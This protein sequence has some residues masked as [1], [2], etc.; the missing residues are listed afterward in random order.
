MS[1]AIEAGTITAITGT[2][3]RPHSLNRRIK[4]R[5]INEGIIRLGAQIFNN[6]SSKLEVVEQGFSPHE[7][8]KFE[9]ILDGKMLRGVISMGHQAINEIPLQHL[10]E[11]MRQEA[12]QI[13]IR[14]FA[15]DH[16]DY[17]G[18]ITIIIGR[19]RSETGLVQSLIEGG[20]T[21]NG[22]AIDFTKP[23]GFAPDT[24]QRRLDG[25][26]TSHS[27][28]LLATT[29]FKTLRFKPLPQN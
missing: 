27:L 29:A 16:S 19:E 26:H 23:D 7:N 13:D 21:P 15:E 9:K 28:F 12:A 14:V 11:L 1:K 25:I 22:E 24:T 10:R 2:L 4:L 18:G 20:M 5:R 8:L 17:P 6:L 3:T